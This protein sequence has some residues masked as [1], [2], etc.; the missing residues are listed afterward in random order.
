MLSII[1]WR[2]ARIAIRIELLRMPMLPQQHQAI[3]FQIMRE[4]LGIK[5]ICA[6]AHQKSDGHQQQYNSSG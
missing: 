1:Q 4:N 6:H 5:A 3:M 2:G